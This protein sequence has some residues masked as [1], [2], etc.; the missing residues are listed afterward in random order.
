MKTKTKK[1]RKRRNL[2]YFVREGFRGIFSHGFM[3]FAAITIMAACL[4]ITGSFSLVAVNIEY[5]LD[6]LME[7]NEFLAYVDD[8][9]TLE[10][11][12]ALQSE[13]EAIDNVAE[14]TFITNEE[15]KEAYLAD[16]NADSDLYDSLP[17]S[18]LRHRYSISV[19]DIGLLSETSSAVKAIDGIADISA[20]LDVANGFVTVRNVV[21]VVTV[22]MV[23]VLLVISLFIVSNAIKLATLA[24]QE[25]IA[26]MKMC[27]A[28]NGFIR[29]PFL[30]EGIILGL[31]SAIIGFLA[32]WG[33]YALLLQAVR[34]SSRMQ[35]VS[36]VSFE[37][38]APIVGAAFAGVGLIVGV[39]GS[40][41]TIRKYLQV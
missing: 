6:K 5:N 40:L 16:I 33:L 24:R 21:T 41:M 14:V 11:A 8:S 9:L 1:R 10:E 15:A 20:A 13:I 34:S 4:L 37:Q 26:I 17:D 3:S 23:G 22:G 30:F 25:E 12:E 32:Q 28:T 7:E 29:M 27:G 31:T 35:L 38:V 19:E 2:G 18:V 36:L 39:C